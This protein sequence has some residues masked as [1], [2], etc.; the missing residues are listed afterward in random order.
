MMK[1]IAITV[2]TLVLAA[3]AALGQAPAPSAPAER[4]V[5]TAFACLKQAGLPG[6]EVEHHGALDRAAAARLLWGRNAH[7]L[8]KQMPSGD[9]GGEVKLFLAISAAVCQGRWILAR[10]GSPISVSAVQACYPAAC[11]G[12]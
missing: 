6:A 7:L 4:T 1:I 9:A 5:E 8:I 11:R 10:S 2:A 3:S 12:Q